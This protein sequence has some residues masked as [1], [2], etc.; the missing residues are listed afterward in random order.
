MYAFLDKRPGELAPP[1]RVLLGALRLWAD[2]LTAG[3]CAMTPLDALYQHWALEGALWPTH[4]FF[5]WV[6]VHARRRIVLGCPT[7]GSVSEDEALLLSAV[8]PAPQVSPD[9]T[10]VALGDL[11]SD[12]ASPQALRL[13]FALGEELRRHGPFVD[14]GRNTGFC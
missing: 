6:S 12:E 10:Q 1:H 9:A 4:N 3:R 5:S 13:A 14:N 2:A 8:F 11:V 7:C